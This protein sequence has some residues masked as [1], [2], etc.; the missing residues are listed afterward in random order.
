[1]FTVVHTTSLGGFRELLV[2]ELKTPRL[3]AETYC[4]IVNG[5]W[6]KSARMGP[7]EYLDQIFGRGSDQ[8]AHAAA[9]ALIS[10]RNCIQANA[11]SPSLC[12]LLIL[13]RG[14]ECSDPRDRVFSMLGLV[15]APQKA[16][17]NRHFPDY[18]LSEEQVVVITLTYL[19]YR[20]HSGHMMFDV[21]AR[22]VF[23]GL[24]VAEKDRA[25]V[26]ELAYV[27]YYSQTFL[28]P[29][30]TEPGKLPVVLPTAVYVV[31]C[32]VLAVV[33]SRLALHPTPQN[34]A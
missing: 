2:N 18:S 32:F 15:S 10:G 3:E 28:L 12:E 17:L 26:L 11:Q 33:T 27:F 31:S 14:N 30:A 20:Y 7:H 34:S 22:M 9:L 13:F 24:G 16:Y 21:D 8:E 1:M 5:N 6:W 23:E 4:E 29:S 25:R 19:L